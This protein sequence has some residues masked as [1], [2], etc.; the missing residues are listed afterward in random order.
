MISYSPSNCIVTLTYSGETWELE[1]N[2]SMFNSDTDEDWVNL[3]EPFSVTLRLA[4]PKV[5][6]KKYTQITKPWYRKERY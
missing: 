4:S 3:F 1:A 2:S 5:K 6:E